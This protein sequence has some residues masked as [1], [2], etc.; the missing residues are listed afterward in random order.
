[1]KENPLQSAATDMHEIFQLKFI[2]RDLA[3]GKKAFCAIKKLFR[4]IFMFA[5]NFRS[6]TLNLKPMEHAENFYGVHKSDIEHAR[7]CWGEMSIGYFQ[8]GKL[9]ICQTSQRISNA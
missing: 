1:M 2:S 5:I 4:E 7:G 9:E 3:R 8:P 6:S